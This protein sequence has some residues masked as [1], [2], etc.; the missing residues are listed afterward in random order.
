M[1]RPARE[2]LRGQ[3]G[4]VGL[5][6]DDRDARTAVADG[7]GGGRPAAGATEHV[8]ACQRAAVDGSLNPGGRGFGRRRPARTDAATVIVLTPVFDADELAVVGVD[9]AQCTDDFA[10]RDAAVEL[11]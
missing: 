10:C 2:D 9:L 11:A 3:D 7:L 5:M 1:Q 6:P 8:H 4:A